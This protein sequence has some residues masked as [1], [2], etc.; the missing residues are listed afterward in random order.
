MRETRLC[1]LHA[2][3]VALKVHADVHDFAVLRGF[4][5]PHTSIV[6]P[7]IGNIREALRLDPRLGLTFRKAV[8]SSDW[9]ARVW[10]TVR[11][12]HGGCICVGIGGLACRLLLSKGRE[13]DC[14]EHRRN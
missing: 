1:G 11:R 14:D 8:R 6:F 5:A 9:G 7:K 12:V 4:T 13:S 10:R 2:D 3:Y